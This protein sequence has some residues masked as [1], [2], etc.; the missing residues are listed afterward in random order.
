M[1]NFAFIVF[2]L[3][4]LTLYSESFNDYF[5]QSLAIVLETKSLLD[6]I[7]SIKI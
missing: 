3:N 7:I 5:T 1:H 6:I 2:I 4:A